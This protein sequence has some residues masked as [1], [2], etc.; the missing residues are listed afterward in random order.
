MVYVPFPDESIIQT[1]FFFICE[2]KHTST[3][4]KMDSC[5]SCVLCSSPVFIIMA[6]IYHEDVKRKYFRKELQGRSPN[7]TKAV[8]SAEKR[9][10]TTFSKAVKTPNIHHRGWSP[11]RKPDYSGVHYSKRPQ[12]SG[13][14]ISNFIKLIFFFNLY[15][16]FH[17]YLCF[18]IF[19][20]TTFVLVHIQGA[21]RATKV[22]TT[23]RI[24]YSLCSENKKMDVYKN[25]CV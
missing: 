3:S 5:V 24:V 15:I 6:K 2:S 10:A 11:Q 17:T 19:D 4:L 1:Q 21:S 14:E 8:P 9:Q 25:P 18:E 20:F 22:T 13:W 12:R 7:Y 16:L 23:L